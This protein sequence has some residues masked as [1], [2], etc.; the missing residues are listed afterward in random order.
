MEFFKLVARYLAS[1]CQV[2]QVG[3]SW[4]GNCQLLEAVI[5][6]EVVVKYEHC[7]RK[8]DRMKPKYGGGA[9]GK[10]FGH[11][12]W[13]TANHTMLSGGKPEIKKVV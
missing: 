8:K 6:A 2:S 5:Q 11:H 3:G 1:L 12:G 7:R 4:L 10:T 13:P 9:P